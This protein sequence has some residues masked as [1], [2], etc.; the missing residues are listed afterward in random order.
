MTE[1]KSAPELSAIDQAE[2]RTSKLGDRSGEK[3]WRVKPALGFRGLLNEPVYTQ[4][5]S[6]RRR[7]TETE[8]CLKK[9]SLKTS[10]LRRDTETQS[11]WTL[12]HLNPEEFE[13]RSKRKRAL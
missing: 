10:R 8:L 5:S 13:S 12:P 6:R 1:L 4:R 9:C 2:G 3:D 11:H 7:A